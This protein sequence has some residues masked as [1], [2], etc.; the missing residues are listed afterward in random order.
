M[1]RCLTRS[2]WGE[3]GSAIRNNHVA[4]IRSLLDYG[5]VGQGSAAKTSVK[6]LEVV[7]AQAWSQL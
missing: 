7:Q 4:L 6:M 5:C 2:E 3:S 1:M